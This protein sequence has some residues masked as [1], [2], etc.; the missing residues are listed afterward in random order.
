MAV[1][2]YGNYIDYN[3]DRTFVAISNCHGSVSECAEF[4]CQISNC[5][6]LVDQGET[7]QIAGTGFTQYNCNCL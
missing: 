7:I 2:L 5:A 1:T 6:Y 3:G 4:Q